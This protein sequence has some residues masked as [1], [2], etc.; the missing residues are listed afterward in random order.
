M[1]A[2][3]VATVTVKSACTW[4]PLRGSRL[5]KPICHHPVASAFSL[6]HPHLS[7]S[8]PQGN[9][10]T[11]ARRWRGLP[12]GQMG[13]RVGWSKPPMSVAA[14]PVAGRLSPSAGTQGIDWTPSLLPCVGGRGGFAVTAAKSREYMPKHRTELSRAVEKAKAAGFRLGGHKNAGGWIAVAKACGYVD[15]EPSKIKAKAYIR[16]K[17]DGIPVEKTIRDHENACKSAASFQRN[18]GW[19]PAVSASRVTGDDFLFSYE[20]RRLRMEA[21][22]LHGA[23]CQCCGASPATGAVMNVDHIKPRRLFPHLALELSNLQVLCHECN[24]GKGNWDQTDWRQSQEEEVE[25]EVA[26]FIRSI[27]RGR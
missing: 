23:R 3:G 4:V 13:A 8:L 22:K 6:P 10:A 1:I 7:M 12:A 27:S 26:Q 18:R 14:M 16:L 21:L 17:F 2:S 9:H 15:E 5:G 19:A 20:W 11:H 25:P 24:H